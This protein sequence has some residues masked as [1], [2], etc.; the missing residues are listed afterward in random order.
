MYSKRLSLCE[1]IADAR[2]SLSKVIT[3]YV[4]CHRVYNF[5]VFLLLLFRV[6]VFV[7]NNI[8]FRSL[9]HAFLL[10]NLRDMTNGTVTPAAV[11]D[12]PTALGKSK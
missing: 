7:S 8:L 3:V 1:Y 6:I 2:A 11:D 5:G 4:F 9:P 12:N 10:Y